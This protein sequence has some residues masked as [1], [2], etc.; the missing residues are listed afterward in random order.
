MHGLPLTA[1][2]GHDIHQIRMTPPGRFGAG[3]G[4]LH[5]ILRERDLL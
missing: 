2:G 4:P 3:A 5:E 1:R